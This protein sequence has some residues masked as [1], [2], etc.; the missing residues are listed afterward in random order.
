MKHLDTDFIHISILDSQTVLVEAMDGVEIDLEKSKYAN[1]LIEN[2]MSNDYRMIINR[3]ADYSI[4]P[5]DV[6]K[7][8]NGQKK[9]NSI[10]IVLNNKPNFLPMSTEKKLFKG[11]LEFFQTIK[12]AHEWSNQIL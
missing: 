10:A 6:Y 3:K 11:K 9:L 2:E 7:I 1:D 12:D 4:I 8:L 5:I